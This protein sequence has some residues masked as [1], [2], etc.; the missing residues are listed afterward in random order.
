MSKKISNRIALYYSFVIIIIVVLLD[1]LFSGMV[2]DMHIEMVRTEMKEK[3]RFIDLSFRLSSR[4]KHDVVRENALMKELVDDIASVIGLRVTLVDGQGKVVADSSVHEIGTLD[5]HRYRSEIRE[6]FETGTGESVRRSGTLGADMFY[7]AFR[8]GPFVIRIAKPLNEIESAN[9]YI[10]RILL[11]LSLALAALGMAMTFVISRRI[12]RP[13]M[14]TIAFADDFSHGE[15]SRRVV[16]YRDDEIGMLQKSLNMLADTLV[17]KMDALVQERQKLSITLEKIHDGIA[18]IDRNRRIVL[19]NRSFSRLAGIARTIEGQVYFEV[20]RGSSFNSTIEYSL[21]HGDGGCFEEEFAGDI[22]CEVTVTPIKEDATLQGML[23]VLHDITEK[24]RVDRL[25]TELVGN[26]SHELKTPV[27]ILKGYMETIR[28]HLSEPDLCAE[29]IR[30]SLVNVERQ[31]S[32]INDMLKLN[33]IETGGDFTWE[34]VSVRETITGCIDLLSQK[35]QDKAV[36]VV[37]SGEYLDLTVSANRFLA[38]EV[39]FN[40]IDNAISYNNPGGSVYI[41][42]SV[43]NGMVKINIIDTGVGIPQESL[44]HIFERFYRVD[45]GRSRETGGTGLGLSIVKH[46]AEILGWDVSVQSGTGG[47]RFTVDIRLE[48]ERL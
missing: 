20:I 10:R 26:L 9:R 13:I 8:S 25:K 32:I 5:N 35:A 16:N 33:R 37:I 39:F 41:D 15:F 44:G 29:M 24:K 28:E 45:K 42:C 36:T 48:K 2:R 31:N 46:A 23:V 1:V 14:D 19:A 17:E 4:F 22:L 40:I 30:K 34:A 47:S 21:S 27:A 6:A 12:T 43:E 18:V 7:Y 38:E 11:T 3:V